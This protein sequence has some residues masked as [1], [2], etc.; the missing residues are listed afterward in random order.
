M[1]R[2]SSV[3]DNYWS[4]PVDD[5]FQELN[6]GHNGLDRAVAADRLQKYGQ[7]RMEI[8]HR[9]SEV[10]WMFLNQFS[11]PLVLI[12]V[13][14]AIVSILIHDWLDAVI[15]LAIILITAVLS[16]VQEYRA[17]NA[18]EKLRQRVFVKS[19]VLRNG[20]T[21]SIPSQEVVPGDI[22]QLTAGSL[23]PGDGVLLESKNFYVSQALLT[24]ETFPVE[25]RPGIASQ[26]SS[27][28]ERTNC[29]FMGTSVRS[30]SAKALIV[31]TGSKTRFGRIADSLALSQPE[32]EFERGLRRF[33]TMLIGV[34]V[35]MMLAIL[36]VNI[37]FQ[38]PTIEAFMFA[39]ALAVGLSPEMLPA[40]LTIT[41]AHGA[42]KMAK[43]GVIVKRLN[44]IEN[45]GSMDV[46]CT[47]KTGTLTKGV[48]KLDNA[49]DSTGTPSASVLH[50]AYLNAR[51]QT[52]LTNPLDDAIIA[53]GKEVSV[54][55]RE[56]QKVDEIPYDFIRKRLSIVITS[57]QEASALMISKGALQ[58]ILDVCDRVQIGRTTE[59][60]SEKHSREIQQHFAEWSK[61]GFRV[62]G[63]A[64]K[65]LKLGKTYTRDDEHEMVFVGF[66]LF[67]DPPEEGISKTLG[68]MCRLGVQLKIIT[69]DN[70]HVAQHVA[71]EV[72]I[73]TE[74]IITGAELDVMKDEALWHLATKV[75]LFAEVDP[76]QKERIISALQRT[77]HVVGYLGDGIN[78]APALH[79]ADVGI[80]VDQAADIAKEAADLILLKHNLK[81]ICKGIHEGRHTFA[82]TLKYIFITTSANFGNMISMALA[83]L[84]L[85]FLPMLAKQILLNNFLSDIPSMGIANDNIDR[86]WDKTPHRWDINLVRNFMIVFG[87]I[88]VV[89]DFMTFGMLLYI[90]GTVS[91][92]FRT[93]WFVESLLT[94]LLIL[95][96]IRS[97]KPFYQSKPSRFL[98][99]S[100]VIVIFITLLL[101]YLGIGKMM[102]FVPLPASIMTAILGITILYVIVSEFTKRIFFHRIGM[103][104]GSHQ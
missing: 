50:L 94:E 5:L 53:A 81:V 39:M 58:N 2:S 34:M 95:F 7:N 100:T 92:V 87:L 54:S 47:D 12:L 88:S 103:I 29:V 91:E 67:F 60:L 40:I 85:P 76:N 20:E 101:P 30:G 93:G 96:V 13:I 65:P 17:A 41:L 73:K 82:N 77:G 11:N 104:K 3:I 28:I 24:G 62:L 57:K 48:V 98:I 55:M 38:H 4:R 18:V 51:L 75:N 36:S 86:D 74:R 52:G 25:K 43:E 61:Q 99:W 56:Y 64:Q 69:G 70:K 9:H 63:I 33:G 22:V 35:I 15:V 97:Y 89:F 21:L 16:F 27:L 102:G 90:S 78:D 46:L 68:E 79:A 66:L 49:M 80:S 1:N 26:N 14:A 6:S 19:M 31:H 32:T 42:Q 23:I 8:G 72:G 45:L 59:L 84:F 37:L 44:V 10:L 71:Q 83:S